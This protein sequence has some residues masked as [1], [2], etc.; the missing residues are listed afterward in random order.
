MAQLASESNLVSL[1]VRHGG[2]L[3]MLGSEA[4][5]LPFREPLAPPQRAAQRERELDRSR[6]ACLSCSSFPYDLS[7]FLPKLFAR[8]PAI[9]Q[10]LG[11]SMTQ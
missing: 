8:R 5:A 4:E 11:P 7:L 2:C 1:P 9:V 3:L 6:R 10:E